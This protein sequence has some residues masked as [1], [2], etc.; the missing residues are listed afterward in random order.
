MIRFYIIVG[1]ILFSFTS[2]SQDCEK[3]L[4]KVNELYSEFLLFDDSISLDST[5][6]I[7]NRLLDSNCKPK[8]ERHVYQFLIKI[9]LSKKN[10]QK[11]LSLINDYLQLEP[12]D[13][14][15]YF[16]RAIVKIRLNDPSYSE[17]LERFISYS[18]CEDFFPEWYCISK[19]VLDYGLSDDFSSCSYVLPSHFEIESF[20]NNYGVL[21]MQSEYR[22]PLPQ[23]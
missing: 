19:V 4:N 16:T 13:R 15:L 1:L 14:E 5:I 7:L 10:D 20:I 3:E 22:G 2:C 17:D 6:Q 21:S 23:K 11:S 12:N 9:H 18:K 8:Q